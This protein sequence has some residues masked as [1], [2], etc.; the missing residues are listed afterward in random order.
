MTPRQTAVARRFALEIL[1]TSQPYLLPAETIQ[2]HLNLVCQPPLS[3]SEVEQLLRGL[4]SARCIVQS[5]G[6]DGVLKSAITQIGETELL[7]NE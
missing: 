4:G 7:K 3:L 6:A 5:T 2:A 1:H